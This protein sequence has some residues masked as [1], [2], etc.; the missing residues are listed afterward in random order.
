MF[1]SPALS[2][3]G[4]VPLSPRTGRPRR[5]ED[6]L[7][8]I[9]TSPSSG[10][11]KLFPETLPSQDQSSFAIKS[12]TIRQR[13]RLKCR[14]LSKSRLGQGFLSSKNPPPWGEPLSPEAK[15]TSFTT[16]VV[17]VVLQGSLGLL[18]FVSVP[19]PFGL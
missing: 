9:L 8:L 15:K 18:L 6:E 14:H 7:G 10:D 2:R 16:R 11:S 19:L 17:L 12:S 5:R 1:L 3:K 4:G 13:V